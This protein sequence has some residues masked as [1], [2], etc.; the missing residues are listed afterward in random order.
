MGVNFKPLSDRVVLEQVEDSVSTTTG[1]VFIPD[2]AKDKPQEAKVVAVGP[3]R[4][5]DDGT[6]ID[7]TVKI[8]DV[9]VYSKYSGTEVKK[10][11]TEYVIVRESD[12]LA[13]VG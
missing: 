7:I 11:G 13:I 12:I 5:T 10:D 2:N 1:G 9:V 4:V 6:R 8:G 3:G